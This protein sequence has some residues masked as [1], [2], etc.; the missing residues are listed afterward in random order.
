LRADFSIAKIKFE[1]PAP[2]VR[3]RLPREANAFFDVGGGVRIDGSSQAEKHLGVYGLAENF[4]RFS[5]LRVIYD[6]PILK[7]LILTGGYGTGVKKAVVN[8]ARYNDQDL[9]LP[10][11]PRGIFQGEITVASLAIHDARFDSN[12]L[13]RLGPGSFGQKKSSTET[14]LQPV[15]YVF[16]LMNDSKCHVCWFLFF[17]FLLNPS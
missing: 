13:S 2:T 1:S 3:L 17:R 14:S 8:I 7:S 16:V 5:I 9:Q 12:R 11:P 6:D 10:L 4:Y 15:C